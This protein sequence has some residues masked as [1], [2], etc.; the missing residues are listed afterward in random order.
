MLTKCGA[1]PELLSILAIALG[2]MVVGC[3][4]STVATCSSAVDSVW[5]GGLSKNT[6][7]AWAPNPAYMDSLEELW[8]PVDQRLRE[9]GI[10]LEKS[11]RELFYLSHE[12]KDQD[13]DHRRVFHGHFVDLTLGLPVTYFMINIPHS[14]GGFQYLVPPTIQIASLL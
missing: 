8:I 12:Y 14:H 9:S 3:K 6:Q 13:Q 11:L 10:R 4:E 5:V 1:C 7:P 2:L